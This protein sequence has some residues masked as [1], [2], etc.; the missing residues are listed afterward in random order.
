MDLDFPRCPEAQ[1]IARFKGGETLKPHFSLERRDI[2]GEVFLKAV[3]N[4]LEGVGSRTKTM[5]PKWT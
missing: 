2:S 4:C 5:T 3:L 1:V